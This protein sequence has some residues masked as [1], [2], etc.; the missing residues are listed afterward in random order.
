MDLGTLYLSD[1]RSFWIHNKTTKMK[2]AAHPISKSGHF[3]ANP[4]LYTNLRFG[5]CLLGK[6]FEEHIPAHERLFE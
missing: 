1:L 5:P 2:K 3:K 4:A 6:V